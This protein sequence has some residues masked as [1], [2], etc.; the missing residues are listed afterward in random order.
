[1]ALIKKYD[2]FI[3]FNE[4]ELLEIRLNIL[5]DFVDYF[6]L[7]ESTKTFTGLDKPLYYL[8]NKN[9]YEKFNNK[10]I[11]IVVDD[12]PNSFDELKN[13]VGSNVEMDIIRDCL[14]TPN[15]PAGEVHWLREFYQ[16][17]QI[18]KALYDIK[19]INDNDFI[20][21]SDLD[22]IWD[23][24]IKINFNSDDIFRYNQAVHSY[25]LNN[26][27]SEIWYGTI[28]TKYK[29]IKNYSINH[30]RTPNRNNYITI[31]NAGWHFNFM[32]GPDKIKIKLESY[33]HQEYNNDV[34]KNNIEDKLTNNLEIFGRPFMFLKTEE[35]LPEYIKNNKNKYIH[36]FK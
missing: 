7:V 33:G 3:F 29:N 28:G 13:R 1:M 6:I 11:H 9:K 34:I 2:T 16:K 21:I 32:G 20:F 19:D 31:P 5:N 17:E 27:S 35:I 18:K 22:E 23:P 12:L 26:F 15:V 10:I 4:L 14:T 36:L 24:N 8:E 30:I 25:Y